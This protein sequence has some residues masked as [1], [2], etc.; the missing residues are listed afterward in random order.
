[1]LTVVAAIIE[2]GVE[3][4]RKLLV[5]QR[6][7]DAAFALKWEFPGGKVKPGETPEAALARELR[8][9]LGVEAR[10]IGREVYRVRHKYQ[11]MNDEL[12]LIFFRAA[13]DAE[14][15]RNLVFEDVR[16]VEPARL[17]DLDFLAADRDLIDQLRRG[18]TAG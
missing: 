8:E 9:E 13:V 4:G 7:R 5:C 14:R 1:V 2:S 11:E 18:I 3:S 12:E 10:I 17:S 16:W 6:R 15:V